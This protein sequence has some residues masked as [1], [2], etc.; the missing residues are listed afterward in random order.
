MRP[1]PGGRRPARACERSTVGTTTQAQ[2]GHRSR[3]ARPHPSFPRRREPRRTHPLFAAAPRRTP[4]SV[5]PV[6][7]RRS[8][9]HPSFPPPPVVPAP[10]R[11]SRPHPSFPPPP[12]VPA[13]S[14]RSRPHPSFPP[15]PVVPA[16]SL[17]VPA[18]AGTSTRPPP[19]PAAHPGAQRR[20]G[21]GAAAGA[22]DRGAGS[23]SAFPPCAVRIRGA[24]ATGGLLRMGVCTSR[25]PPPRER[26]RGARTTEG[27]GGFQTRPYGVER[28]RCQCG[29]WRAP[30]AAA[31]PSFVVP[32]P[33]RHSREGGNRPVPTRV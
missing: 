26:R 1:S 31:A 19:S 15:P 12:V 28:D 24:R 2:S 8:R 14:R 10:T 21:V 22:S 9:P 18:E 27:E 3:S 4:S 13:P 7:I 23:L 11:R 16:P 6:L 17:V 32:A 5:V 25:F 29:G 33:I 20:G 30:G